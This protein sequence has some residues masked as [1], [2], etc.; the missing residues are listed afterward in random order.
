MLA[1]PGVF[2][3]WE[4]GAGLARGW[5]GGEVVK[6][7]A[8]ALIWRTVWVCGLI[9]VLATVLGFPAGWVSRKLPGRWAL[10]MVAPMLMPSYLAYAGWGLLRAPGTWLGDWLLRGP[11]V[12]SGTANA[13]VGSAAANWWPVAASHAQAVL[14]LVL[15]CRVTSGRA[16]GGEW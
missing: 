1:W 2:V 6:W 10:L 7:P 5:G 14:G 12:G 13:A 11:S 3:V 8:W 16:A 15:T 9:A 4:I